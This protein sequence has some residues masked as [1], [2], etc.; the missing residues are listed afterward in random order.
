MTNGSESDQ[1]TSR[2]RAPIDVRPLTA[3]LGPSVRGRG[4]SP[5]RPSSAPQAVLRP[6]ATVLSCG[7]PRPRRTVTG[8]RSCGG[9]TQQRA[10]EGGSS[11]TVTLRYVACVS[12]KIG[13][14]RRSF[15][16]R[17]G[18]TSLH[19]V[20]DVGVEGESG[21]GIGRQRGA[22]A[23]IGPAPRPNALGRSRSAG[24]GLRPDP[25]GPL[26]RSRRGRGPRRMLPSAVESPRPGQV[27]LEL[28][29]KGILLSQ[30]GSRGD[31]GPP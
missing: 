27:L 12:S 30:L 11:T 10:D 28:R 6:R 9:T 23:A 19:H 8:H 17:C 14:G 3:V 25:P 22:P 7:P 24:R 5:F 21:A 31:R 1:A 26:C 13:C 18:D 16:R 29:F 20:Q 4:P 15:G 2:L